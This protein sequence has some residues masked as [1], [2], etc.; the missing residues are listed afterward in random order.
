M[1]DE[2]VVAC[3]KCS[4]TM[5]KLITGGIGTVLKGGGWSSDLKM[6]QDLTKKNGQAGKK[7]KD[8]QQPVRCLD[9]LKK[10]KGLH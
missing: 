10:L 9:D 5:R 8:H 4:G 3:A 2:P 6:K 1:V 7:M